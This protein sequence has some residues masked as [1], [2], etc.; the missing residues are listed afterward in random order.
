MKALITGITGQDGSYLAE[1]LLEKGYEVYGMVRRSSTETFDRIAHIKDRITLRPGRPARPAVADQAAGGH[2]ARRDL[3]PGRHVASCRPRGASRC[4]PASSPAIGVT[5][6][7]RGHAPVCPQGP[8]LPGLQQ[9]DVR[10]GPRGAAD[11]ADALLSAQPLRRRQGLR[12]LHHRQLPRE[13]RPV[14]RLRH[15]LQ[16]REPAPRQGV[17]HPQDHRRRRPHQARPRTK[18]LRMGNLDAKRDWGFAGDYVRAMWLML[19]QD[20]PDDYVI[21][22]GEHPLRARV[23]RDSPSPTSALHWQDYVVIDPASSARPRSTTCSATAPRPTSKLGWKPD[24][25]LRGA[26]P[27]DGRRRPRG[28]LRPAREVTLGFLPHVDQD[29]RRELRRLFQHQVMPRRRQLTKVQRA[30]R[31]EAVAGERLALVAIVG[32]EV[33]RCR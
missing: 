10:Q 16:P 11:R 13:L 24:G 23:P 17:R 1:L 5:R 28:T 9:R 8:L 29:Q 30:R 20:K 26:R 19:Q 18:K 25:Q 21:A 14:R 27:H 12:P 3:Q 32:Q 22:T 7:A 6:A 31:A 15:P 4:S 2:A 33:A